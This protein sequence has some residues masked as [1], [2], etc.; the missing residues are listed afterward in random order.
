M[1][2]QF[3]SQLHDY[4]NVARDI[5]HTGRK[6]NLLRATM[7]WHEGIL[8]TLTGGRTGRIYPVPGTGQIQEVTITTR[9][10]HR[11]KVRKLVGATMYTASAPGQAPAILFGQLRQSYQFRVKGP[12]F[13]EVGEVGSPLL[14]AV[15]LEKGT[16]RIAPRPHVKEGFENNRAEI[17]KQLRRRW[18]E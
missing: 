15:W 14:K 3:N 1:V 8:N 13:K 7:A 17:F 16:N 10:G 5:L 6:R 9:R 2:L 11:M 4:T 12:N 18:D